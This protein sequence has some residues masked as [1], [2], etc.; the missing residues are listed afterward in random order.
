MRLSYLFSQH[1]DILILAAG[2]L[3]LRFD[4]GNNIVCM[5]VNA[6]GPEKW[7][8]KA[9]QAIF[10][11]VQ[12]IYEK[13][14]HWNSKGMKFCSRCKKN[15]PSNLRILC[16]KPK[17]P[18]NFFFSFHLVLAVEF[19]GTDLNFIESRSIN[20]AIDTQTN[21]KFAFLVLLLPATRWWCWIWADLVTDIVWT[22]WL[23]SS[24]LQINKFPEKLS[25]VPAR[26]DKK[27]KNFSDALI[28]YLTHASC[29]YS[30][31]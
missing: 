23:N 22:A 17:S 15:E 18:V 25:G 10:L 13:E 30:K 14:T 1:L 11:R 9:D 29:C 19:G 7:P 6:I 4:P 16:A 27:S 3:I 28:Y 21:K 31:R 24:W 20:S 2:W 12:Q 26:E 5:F 8:C